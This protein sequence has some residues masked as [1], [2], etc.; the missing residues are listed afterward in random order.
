MFLLPRLFFR[1][2]RAPREPGKPHLLLITNAKRN[3]GYYRDSELVRQTN[4]V[5]ITE[6]FPYDRYDWDIRRVLDAIYGSDWPDIIYVH[7]SRH[8]THRIR[9]LDKVPVLKIGFVGDPQ[10]F[11]EQEEKHVVKRRWLTEAGIAA[12]MTIAP[13]ANWMV[14][15]GLGDDAIPIVD[16]HLAVEPTVFRD[17]R[18]HR[19][20]DIGSFGAHTDQKYPFRI[21]ARQF[22]LS[23]KE[24]TYNRRQRV[25]RGGNDAAA[26]AR[27]LNR[28][29]SCFTCAS[30]YGYTV[31]KYFEI[32]ACGTLL[33]GERTSLL[34]EFG[35][36]DG[37]NFVEVS[38][39]N[40]KDKFRY[41][42]REIHPDD[43]ARIAQAGRELVVSRHTWRHRVEGIVQGFREL[44]AARPGAPPPQPGIEK[45]HATQR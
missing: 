44:L 25:G 5:R 27:E 39:E 32:P 18:R 36:R 12:Y 14:R 2:P 10:D 41:Y 1:L 23:Q 34:D 26:F 3:Q 22:L 15:K 33:F 16:S 45:E 42:L 28:Y 20:V 24:Y 7:Y 40:F 8:Y 21:Q 9:H 6:E 30:V 17:L 31:A 35:Y 37:V 38:P 4:G 13:Q 43:R 11:L 19:R 29:I